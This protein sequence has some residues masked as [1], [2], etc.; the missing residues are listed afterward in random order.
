MTEIHDQRGSG[1]ADHPRTPTLTRGWTLGAGRVEEIGRA[2]VAMASPPPVRRALGQV[3]AGKYRLAEQIGDGGMGEVWLAHH[4]TLDVD[5][6]L[7]FTRADLLDAGSRARLNRE[8]RLVARLAHPSVVRVLDSGTTE[9]G[10]P[11]MVMELLRGQSLGATL[12]ERTRLSKTAAVRIMLPVASALSAAH[13]AGIVH[14]DLKPDNVLLVHA[15]SGAITP[16]VLDFGIAKSC[17]VELDGVK[18]MEGALMGSPDYMSP[19]QAAG[20]AEIDAR[21]DVWSYCLLFY[22]IVTGRHPFARSSLGDTLRAILHEPVAPIVGDG[23]L[24]SI[25]ARGLSKHPDHRWQSIRELGEQLAAWAILQGIHEDSTGTSIHAEW[26][27]GTS[28]PLSDAPARAA[29]VPP[30]PRIQVSLPPAA[31]RA[32][33]SAPPPRPPVRSRLPLAV[34]VLIPAIAIALL[35]AGAAQ[36]FGAGVPEAGQE[37]RVR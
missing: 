10:S 2:L 20:V 18:T 34:R 3:V 28:R 32:L 24:W 15:T 37:S 7:K 25:I 23:A 22:E 8:A 5:V 6:A 13:A 14:R 12:A 19:E 11:Y 4:L 30:L 21:S 27:A 36:V 26:L 16:K 9:D 35:A 29:I 1:G 31:I 17:T 33:S